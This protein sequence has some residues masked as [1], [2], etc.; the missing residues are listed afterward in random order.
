VSIA[1]IGGLAGL[2]LFFPPDSTLVR[3]LFFLLI[4][5]GTFSLGIFITKNVR[6][7]LLL[8]IGL[9]T[10]LLLRSFGLRQFFYVVLL[11]GVLISL[12]LI[13]RKR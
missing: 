7:S 5:L 1:S 13:A 8:A 2:L 4:F 10:Y 9:T 3:G 6:R 12:E 11:G